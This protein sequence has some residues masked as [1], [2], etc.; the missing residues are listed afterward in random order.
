VL[1]PIID[2]VDRLETMSDM[3]APKTKRLP[4]PG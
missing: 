4:R 3:G 1:R 2:V